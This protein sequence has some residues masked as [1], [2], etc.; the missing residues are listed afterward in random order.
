MVSICIATYNGSKYIKEQ[1]DSIISQIDEIDEIIISDDSSTDDTLKI[2]ESYNSKQ[3]KIYTDNI[4]HSPIYNFENALS[5]AKGDYIFLCDQ[6]DI[7]LPNKIKIMKAELQKYDLVVS[8]CRVVDSNLNV[9]EESIFKVLHSR[10]GFFKN[11]IKNTYTGCCMAFKKEVLEYILPFPA[12]IAMHDIWIGLS[13]ELHGTVHFI[14]QPLILYR[15][16]GE[17]ASFGCEK[18]C[19]SIW[20]KIQYRMQLL[21]YLLQRK[22][23]FKKRVF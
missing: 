7:W 16:H 23:Q 9:K 2:V 8:D 6:D 18:S 5:K 13:V 12:S 20:Y 17:N 3:I 10:P 19:Y 21:Y 1:L 4:Y 11:L 22:F 15:R 14:D